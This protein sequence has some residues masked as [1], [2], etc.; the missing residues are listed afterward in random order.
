MKGD[1][2]QKGEDSKPGILEL[3]MCISR[4]LRIGIYN[5]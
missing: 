4:I 3:E 2:K 1:R 5:F